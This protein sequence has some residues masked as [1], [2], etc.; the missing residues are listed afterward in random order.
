MYQP[1]SYAIALFFI[2][3]AMICWGSWANTVKLCP[4]YRFHLVYWDYVGGLVLGAIA[5]GLTLGIR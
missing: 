1:Q 4:R 5:W 3:V 2:I